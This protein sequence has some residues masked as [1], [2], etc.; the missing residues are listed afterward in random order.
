MPPGAHT[1]KCLNGFDVILLQGAAGGT[2]A[3]VALPLPDGLIDIHNVNLDV[4]GLLA[5]S[6]SQNTKLTPPTCCLLT[7]KV[8]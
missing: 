2:L 6:T 5:I 7:M 1:N 3:V 4:I 8:I